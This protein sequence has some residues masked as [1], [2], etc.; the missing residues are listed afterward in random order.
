V[1]AKSTLVPRNISRKTRPYR[2]VSLD[3]TMDM[4]RSSN[5]D[6]WQSTS[7]RQRSESVAD[8][9]VRQRQ[10]FVEPRPK[11]DTWRNSVSSLSG[12]VVL[13]RW[14]SLVRTEA[15]NIIRC[16]NRSTIVASI[17]KRYISPQ[18]CCSKAKWNHNCELWSC[19]TYDQHLERH[20]RSGLLNECPLNMSFLGSLSRTTNAIRCRE[21]PGKLE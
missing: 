7:L 2:S 9:R 14:R 3:K 18:Q 5:V 11:V 8:H 15:L 17:E 1:E 10:T 13:W 21:Y 4:N 20:G 6:R 12:S 19:Q 16:S